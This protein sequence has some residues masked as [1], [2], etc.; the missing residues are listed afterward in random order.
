MYPVEG[1]TTIASR[2]QSDDDWVFTS[3]FWELYLHEMY[4]RDNWTIAVEPPVDG[5]NTRPDF[6][7]SKGETA[8]Y[9]EARC[10]FS[11]GDRGAAARLQS[12]YDSLNTM[13]SGAFHLAVTP[14]KIGSQSP[15]TGKLR[16]GLELWLAGLDPDAGD[17]SL[18]D[19]RPDRRFEWSW[20]DWELVFFPMPR[21][22]SARNSPAKRALGAFIPAEAAFIDDISPLEEALSEKGS[23][24]G[25]LDHPLVIAINTT[26]GFHDEEDTTQ[27]LYGR[28]G[29]RI[30]VEDPQAEATPVLANEGYWGR[31][32]RP[33]HP[34][35]AG[36]LLA[37]GIHYSQ[38]SKYA[39]TFWPNPYASETIEPLSNWKVAQPTAQGMEYR[40]PTQLPHQYFGLEEGWPIGDPFPRC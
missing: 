26:S 14:I 3:A 18:Q 7:V 31:P 33:G 27:A 2:L 5:V 20:Q 36:L 21:A 30:D 24:Y 9:V 11:R 39:P 17:F 22:A 6:L 4:R 16:R 1:R 40:R 10:L 38:V 15:P 29:W 35:V 8:Y 37:E 34:H 23:K 28:I 19:D 32:G 13:D 25:S 12:V